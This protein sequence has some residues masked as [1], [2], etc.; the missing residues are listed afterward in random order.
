MVF[1]SAAD[2]EPVATREPIQFREA[3]KS[4]LIVVE[5]SNPLRHELEALATR[6]RVGLNV[7]AESN[8]LLMIRSLVESG[9]ANCILPRCSVAEKAKV[10]ALR[11]RPIVEPD[12]SQ[13]YLVAWPKSRPL[14][15]AARVAVD[16]L[17]REFEPKGGQH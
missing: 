5:R 6:H 9:A 17:Q 7:K 1:V 3:A 8:S 14:I 13:R 2:S 12:L 16:L 11:T 10:G 4:P 15:R